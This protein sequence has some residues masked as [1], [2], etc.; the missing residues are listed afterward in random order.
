M[1]KRTLKRTAA[2]FLSALMLLGCF[3]PAQA[4]VQAQYKADVWYNCSIRREPDE[5]AYRVYSLKE[6]ERIN[7]LEYGEEWCKVE[8]KGNV[9]YVKTSW[10][11]RFRS[12]DATRYQV[13]GYTYQSGMATATSPFLAYSENYDGTQVQ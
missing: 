6:K 13:P 9:G 8:R 7:V 5:K 10:L 12:L 4:E 2:L 3:P 11:V 1:M